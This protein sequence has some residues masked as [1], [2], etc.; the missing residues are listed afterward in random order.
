MNKFS[1]NDFMRKCESVEVSVKLTNDAVSLEIE[2][3]DSISDDSPIL[4]ELR[5]HKAEVLSLLRYQSR[6]EFCSRCGPGFG[7]AMVPIHND[8]SIRIDCACCGRFIRW[9][10]WNPSDG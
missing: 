8:R 10:K 1:V 2:I 5:E 7:L 4:S 3:P 6:W 9:E